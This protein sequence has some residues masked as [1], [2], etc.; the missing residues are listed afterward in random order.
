MKTK[1]RCKQAKEKVVEKFKA[2]CHDEMSLNQIRAQK[3]SRIEQKFIF[4]K[5]SNLKYADRPSTA[6]KPYSCIR[7]AQSKK[8]E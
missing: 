8:L 4:R 5:D 3:Y 7:M 1:E 6:Y 2:G